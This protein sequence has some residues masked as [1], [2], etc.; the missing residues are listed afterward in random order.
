MFISELQ[1]YDKKNFTFKL[2]KYVRVKYNKV[3]HTAMVQK[4]FVYVCVCVCVCVSV[5]VC[6]CVSVCVCECV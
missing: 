3:K 5:C 6:V 1:I 2:K 4:P